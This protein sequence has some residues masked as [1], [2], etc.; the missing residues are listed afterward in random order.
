MKGT[1]ALVLALVMAIGLM[2]FPVSADFTDDADIKYTEAVGGMSA[3]GVIDG[4]EGG[5]FDPDGYLTREQA[6]KVVA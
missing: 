6:A 2:A 4:F 5:S 1:L 3:I